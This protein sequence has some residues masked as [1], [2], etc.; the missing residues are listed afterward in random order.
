M[1]NT[2]QAVQEHKQRVLEDYAESQLLG[3]YV[4]GSQNYG[5]STENSDVDTKAILIPS[6]EDLCLKKPV[7]REIHLENNE[8][9][10]VKDIRELVKMFTKQNINFLEI[11]YSDYC[12]INPKYNRIWREYFVANREYISHINERY[13][14]LSICGQAIHTLNQ[15]KTDGKKF[16]NGLR[17]Y[18]FLVNY[19][20]GIPYGFC[21]D[22]NYYGKG[23]AEEII[24]YK[25]NEIVVDEEEVDTLISKFMW[26]KSIAEKYSDKP[27]EYASRI[28]E[29]GVLALITNEHQHFDF[30]KNK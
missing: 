15:D 12:W 10:E 27:D 5:I 9:C 21:I 3:I 18:H 29:D 8:H 1:R 24:A 13:A 30:Y 26:F 25:K 17:L 4:Y 20:D 23:V 14:I 28:L 22:C 19:L 2:M 11:L 16:A 7:S 6:I